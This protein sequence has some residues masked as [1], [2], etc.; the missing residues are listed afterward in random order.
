MRSYSSYAWSVYKPL[1]ILIL[2]NVSG[3]FTK[4]NNE[5]EWFGTAA[6]SKRG[7]VN[8]LIF[9]HPKMCCNHSKIWTMWLYHRV[10]SPNDADGMAN[11][12]DPDQTDC[13]DLGLHCLPRHVCPKTKN[14]YGICV[15]RIR[16]SAC[17]SMVLSDPRRRSAL[18]WVPKNPMFLHEDSQV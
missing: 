5:N 9:G 4:A 17:T 8:F 7:T 3:T 14:H 1:D 6:N 13:S 10:M 16:R 12:V 15:Q 11:S 2:Q 18:I